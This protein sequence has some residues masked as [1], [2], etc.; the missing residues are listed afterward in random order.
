MFFT[1]YYIMMLT[2]MFS[3][4]GTV[5]P[6]HQ[7]FFNEIFS[8][9]HSRQD[10]KFFWHFRDWLCPHLQSVAGGLVEPSLMTRCPTLCCVYLCSAWVWDGC[11]PSG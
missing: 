4:A 1:H 5:S 8:G 7:L 10:V 11:D 9:R 3:K 6:E 2:E